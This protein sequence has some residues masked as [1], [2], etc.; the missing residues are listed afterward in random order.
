MLSSKQAKKTFKI[1]NK[2]EISLYN[3]KKL[4]TTI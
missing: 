4:F 2:K 1:F 3:G